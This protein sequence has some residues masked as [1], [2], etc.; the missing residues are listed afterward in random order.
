MLGPMLDLVLVPKYIYMFIYIYKIIYAHE[1]ETNAPSLLK[2]E[3]EVEAL[4]RVTIP[5]LLLSSFLASSCSITLTNG[6]NA[7]QDTH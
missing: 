7:L 3:I 1:S 4:I 5:G 6:T 2:L